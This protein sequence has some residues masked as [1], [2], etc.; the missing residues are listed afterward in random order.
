LG[1]PIKTFS[2]GFEERAYNELDAAGEVAAAFGTE[3]HSLHLTAKDVQE[4]LPK[5]IGFLD[6]PLADASVVPTY[7]VCRLAREHVKVAL[8]GDGGDESFGGYETYKAHK[9]AR[10]YRRLPRFV[11]STVRRAVPLLPASTSHHGFSFKA[12]KFTS[13]VEYAPA[14]ANALWWGAY[15]PEMREQLVGDRLANGN[16]HDP[17]EAVHRTEQ[18]FHGEDWLNR[19]LYC[20][21]K[22]Y[23]QDDLLVKVDRMSMANSLEVRVPFLDHTLVEFA[24]TIPSRLKLNGLRLKYILR[25]AMAPLLPASIVRRPKRGFDIPLDAWMRGPLREFVH[26]TLSTRSAQI[27]SLLNPA[28]LRRTLGDHMDGRQDHRQLLWPLLVFLHWHQRYCIAAQ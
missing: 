4:L 22:L 5:I 24:A 21:L 8:S 26:D 20:D 9:I 27:T 18:G 7:L 2:I 16:G 17:F 13:G 23:L 3:H 11:R 25:K 28:I 6:E 19:I 12:R 10:Y 14:V 1:V 15:T